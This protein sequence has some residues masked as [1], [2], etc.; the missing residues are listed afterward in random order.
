M[1]NI[2]DILDI[3]ISLAS[4][5]VGTDSLTKLLIASG[6]L[7][8]ASL[9]VKE[10]SSPAA[11]LADTDAGVTTADQV[12]KDAVTAFQS[13]LRPKSIK[14]AK[15]DKT[16]FKAQSETITITTA[17]DGD[18]KIT[19]NG[20]EKTYVASG[21]ATAAAIAAGL[22]DAIGTSVTNITIDYTASQ[23]HFHVVSTEPG[24]SHTV[25]LATAPTTG[26]T[27][28][29]TKV[30]GQANVG[31]QEALT[32]IAAED[33]VWYG[34]AITDRHVGHLMECA[35]W[36]E[37]KGLK[38]FIGQASQATMYSG[39]STTDLAYVLKG[40]AYLRT[41]LQYHATDTEGSGAGWAANRLRVDPDTASTIWS[42]V[43]L[44][45][46]TVDTLDETAQNALE[47]K[48]CNYYVQWGP[49]GITRPGVTCDGTK[50]NV[51]VSKDWLQIRLTEA[52]QQQLIDASNRGEKI[53]FDNKGISSVQATAD[54]VFQRGVAAKH[55]SKY[56]LDFPDISD[57]SASDK[58]AGRLRF[59]F[60]AENLGGIEGLTVT[61]VVGV[62]V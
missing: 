38:L 57:V 41:V 33:D 58:T 55:F 12:Y 61:G 47:A 14:L 2:N 35:I 24:T 37:A 46:V 53:P 56:E 6:D 30:V 29:W 39:A 11:I 9:L 28:A 45:G 5:G 16:A 1:T 4:G 34:L 15:V 25:T 21:S 42:F 27:G 48:N 22:A 52:L 23:T 51:L 60:A 17:A 7:G 10:Y 26:A 8:F 54:A 44:T 36:T 62:M 59:T 49:A 20:V 32:L 50:V 18:W 31:Y 43:T 40:L 19:I 13:K 3:S